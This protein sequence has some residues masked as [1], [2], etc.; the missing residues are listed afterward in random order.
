MICVIDTETSGF[1]AGEDA[2]VEVAGVRIVREEGIYALRDCFSTYVAPGRRIPPEAMAVH[3]IRDEDVRD[4]PKL[5]EAMAVLRDTLGPTEFWAAH[6]MAF[7]G[8]FLGPLIGDR[9]ICTWRAAKHMFPDLPSYKNQELRY[10]LNLDGQVRVALDLLGCAGLPPHRA[11][12]DTV[13]TSVLLLHMLSQADIEVLEQLSTKP[14]LQK[15]CRFGSKHRGLN[16][17]AVPRDY[18]QWMRRTVTDMD[19]DT[20][21]TVDFYLDGGSLQQQTGPRGVYRGM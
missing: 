19:E 2:V 20:K 8:A 14:V 5:P 6:N 21:H 13:V 16:W 11:L 12:Y 7:D 3:H 15:V 18:L 1:R 17:S 10:R 4:A 9:R